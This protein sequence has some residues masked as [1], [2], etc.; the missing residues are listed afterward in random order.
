MGIFN[1]LMLQ[2]IRQSALLRRACDGAAV[3]AQ[4]SDSEHRLKVIQSLDQAHEQL[5]KL[6]EAR[7]QAQE[8][9]AAYPACPAA[10]ALRS[11]LT[12]AEPEIL[13]PDL[14]EKLRKTLK[15]ITI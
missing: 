14:S 2:L 12:L 9:I 5:P 13:D 3:Y 11:A 15:A 8:L 6:R 10:E 4:I 1:S 7:K